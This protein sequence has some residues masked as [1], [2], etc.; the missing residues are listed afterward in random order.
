[1]PKTKYTF[2]ILPHFKHCYIL[3]KGNLWAFMHTKTTINRSGLIGLKCHKIQKAGTN[4]MYWYIC[5]FIQH[6]KIKA[7]PDNKC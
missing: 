6:D 5:K 3:I 7:K 2:N 1:M 4:F